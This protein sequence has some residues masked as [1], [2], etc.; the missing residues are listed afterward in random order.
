MKKGTL[1]AA[2]TENTEGNARELSSTSSIRVINT[3]R[4]G[5]MYSM[6]S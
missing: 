1:D 5:S 4:K 2:T 3:E 6:S